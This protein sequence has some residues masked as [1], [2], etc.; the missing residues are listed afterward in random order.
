MFNPTLNTYF[1]IDINNY[2]L[3]MKKHANKSQ[4]N[5]AHLKESSFKSIMGY[6]STDNQLVIMEGLNFN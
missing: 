3:L 5:F 2:L 4:Y 1:T 6:Y